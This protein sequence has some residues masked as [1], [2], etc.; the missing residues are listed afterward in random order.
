MDNLV[1]V[2]NLTGQKGSE[3]G[4][5]ASSSRLFITVEI[6]TPYSVHI[7]MPRCI[8]GYQM[9]LNNQETSQLINID[10][11]KIIFSPLL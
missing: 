8:Q 9:Y 2:L 4:G 10:K 5:K 7:A 3:C 1:Q 11:K 6:D